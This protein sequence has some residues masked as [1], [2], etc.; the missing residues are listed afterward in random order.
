M[1][2]D[3][4][5]EYS[6]T[7]AEVQIL[8]H[9][10]SVNEELE[11]HLL[12]QYFIW[13][14]PWLQVVDEALFRESRENN[15]RYFTPLLLNCILASGSRFSDRVE[16]RSDPNDPNTA[17]RIFLEAA[18]VLLH[19]DLKRPSITTIQS[20]AVL[21]TVYHVGSKSRRHRL[22]LTLAGFRTR[23]RR[24]AAFRHGKSARFRHG[25]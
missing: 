5:T 1:P 14:Q 9:Q 4:P 11:A 23:C 13:E 12:E 25:T 2:R 7:C 18:E 16:V 8:G 21:G 24:V 19:F 6:P 22:F 20:L 17:G 3:L 15:G 10:S